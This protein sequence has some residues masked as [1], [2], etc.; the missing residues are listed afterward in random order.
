MHSCIN[1]VFS[2]ITNKKQEA[3]NITSE[4][5]TLIKDS[6]SKACLVFCPHTSAGL[7]INEGADLDVINEILLAID[8]IVPELN[9]K[10]F[11][12]FFIGSVIGF[13]RLRNREFEIELL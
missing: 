1:I 13:D 12:I 9:Y 4:I 8:K 6:K 10:H 11:E 5:E 3:V 2:I 7:V